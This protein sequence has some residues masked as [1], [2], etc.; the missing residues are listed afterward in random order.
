ME[1][2]N[3]SKGIEENGFF[4]PLKDESSIIEPFYYIDRYELINENTLAEFEHF[5]CNPY[6][7][8]KIFIYSNNP[9]TKKEIVIAS[10]FVPIEI[11]GELKEE[12][13]KS[14][15]P[16]NLDKSEYDFSL[17]EI[18]AKEIN[19]SLSYNPEAF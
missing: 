11:Q 18:N 12:L 14:T 9:I 13:L 4:E 7:F 19:L 6:S 15:Q 17:K 8:E 5:K 3:F 16:S 10:A 2:E 1:N